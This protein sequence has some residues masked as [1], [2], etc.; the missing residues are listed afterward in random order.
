M[1]IRGFHLFEIV[2][3]FPFL[4]K[5]TWIL[6]HSVNKYFLTHIYATGKILAP[7]SLE[8]IK[9]LPSAIYHKIT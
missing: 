6:Y 4:D 7:Y 5:K 3:T 1:W 9:Y 8:E 2:N